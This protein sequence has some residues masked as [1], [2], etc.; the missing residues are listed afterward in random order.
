[1]GYSEFM[2]GN[3][4]SCLEANE[5]ALNINSMD[6]YAMGGR[7]LA[8]YRLGQTDEGLRV[9]QEAVSLSGGQ[10]PNLLQDLRYMTSDMA[11]K[12]AYASK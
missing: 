1:M 2:C 4:E 3:Y 8:L 12:A 9:M 6:T 11:A 10:D 5:K 7:A